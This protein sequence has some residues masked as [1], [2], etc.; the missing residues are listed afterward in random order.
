M[1]NITSQEIGQKIR[2]MFPSEEA[3]VIVQDLTT[4]VGSKDFFIVIASDEF[5]GTNPQ[6]VAQILERYPEFNIK[7]IKFNAWK[8]SDGQP[9]PPLY[10]FN[11]N[12]IVSIRGV[13]H[14]RINY[15]P[16]VTPPKYTY[17]PVLWESGFYLR[18][19]TLLKNITFAPSSTT[20]NMTDEIKNS[21]SPPL[22]QNNFAG[23]LTQVETIRT[24]ILIPEG[25][26][27]RA[28]QNPGLPAMVIKGSFIV[29]CNPTTTPLK[30][31]IANVVVYPTG[32]FIATGIGTITHWGTNYFTT[33]LQDT[34]FHYD[35]FGAAQG[36]IVLGGTFEINGPT[37]YTRWVAQ[38][39][40]NH[41]D[42]VNTGLDVYPLI[43]GPNVVVNGYT[44]TNDFVLT[45][46]FQAVYGQTGD[47][48]GYGRFGN[49][50]GGPTINLFEDRCQ[51]TFTGPAK[52]TLTGIGFKI[53]G[54]TTTAPIDNTIWDPVTDTITHRGYNQDNRYP[55]NFLHVTN[56]VMIQESVLYDNGDLRRYIFNIIRT[57]GKFLN[58]SISLQWGSECILGFIH[59][60]EEWEIA[61]NGFGGVM[62]PGYSRD[63]RGSCG[64][65]TRS[66]FLKFNFNFFEGTID[67][68]SIIFDIQLGR[69]AKYG[70]TE[71]LI[72]SRNGKRLDNS[73]SNWI[74]MWNSMPPLVD[75]YYVGQCMPRM[76]YNGPFPITLA[77]NNAH[78]LHAKGHPDDINQTYN[79]DLVFFGSVFTYVTLDFGHDYF[80]IPAHAFV[81][82]FNSL[83]ITKSEFGVNGGLFIDLKIKSF[84][85]IVDTL[86]STGADVAIYDV[87]PLLPGAQSYFRD[88]FVVRRPTTV[89]PINLPKLKVWS[90]K[91]ATISPLNGNNLTFNFTRNYFWKMEGN[92]TIS[93]D[94]IPTNVTFDAYNV[95]MTG[96]NMVTIPAIPGHHTFVSR[97]ESR[98]CSYANC[99][100][101]ANFQQQ[102]IFSSYEVKLAN[103]NFYLG[104]DMTNDIQSRRVPSLVLGN[105]W[106]KCAY[107]SD[108]CIPDGGVF[109]RSTQPFTNFTSNLGFKVLDAPSVAMLTSYYGESPQDKNKIRIVLPPGHYQF[110]LY[111][112]NVNNVEDPNYYWP[113]D[114]NFRISIDG[115]VARPYTAKKPP[116][117]T[118][119]V[120]GPWYWNNLG[121]TNATAL[122]EFGSSLLPTRLAGIVVTSSTQTTPYPIPNDPLPTVTPSPTT[123]SPTPTPTETPTETPDTESPTPTQTITQEPGSEEPTDT[124]T[125]KP[126]TTSPTTVIS[127]A[128]S[129]H[130]PLSIFIIASIIII[131]MIQVINI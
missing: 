59:G 119:S 45:N 40:D 123:P 98:R 56:P 53:L 13:K 18:K 73:D 19:H 27:I 72:G 76:L 81:G 17:Y 2:A 90:P 31:N 1:E 14:H 68:G 128:D 24:V 83:S 80:A 78:L 121:T 103:Y 9:I 105:N 70:A 49:H 124:P 23:Q 48:L 86:D 33:L 79:V 127:S 77:H 85:S 37:K 44:A 32:S 96:W 29:T 129:V 115:K 114:Q 11:L 87:F 99:D 113:T 130:Q 39:I 41:V 71:R 7:G 118:Y 126:I 65:Y 55:F 84:M 16:E 34:I 107:I 10:D 88:H 93:I 122:I 47:Y 100:L 112:T 61:N 5:N 101:R 120:H 117:R 60:T 35:P 30:I 62:T 26:E 94:D 58:N 109:G 92:G 25:L 108:M 66:P 28:C 97:L 57:N 95:N 69:A 38:S 46:N 22:L 110:T 111:F 50:G 21:F 8:K 89:Q 63:Y 6:V 125:R 3:E 54:N 52:V 82:T 4:M 15:F 74:A 75:H 131:S 36:F 91:S 12:D 67:G 43:P 104:I 116:L 102:L 42:N 20:I 64:V 51:Y 106:T